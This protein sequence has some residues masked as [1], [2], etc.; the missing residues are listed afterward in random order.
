MNKS[1]KYIVGAVLLYILSTGISY[2]TFSLVKPAKTEVVMSPLPETAKKSSPSKFVIDP[3]LPKTEVCPLNG[4]RYPKKYRDIWETR[5]PLAVMIENSQDARPQSGISLADVIYESVA[6]GGTTRFMAM[7]YCG[8]TLGNINLAPVRSARIYY[9]PWVLEYDALYNHVG[10]A[11]N[12]N[13]PT[14]D[15]R[16]KALCAIGKWGIK[17]MDQFGISFPD[18]YRNYDRLDHPVATEHTMVC[19]TDNLYKIAAKRGFTNVDEDGVSWDKNFTPWKFKDDAKPNDRGMVA[20]I[21]YQFWDGYKQY[22]AHWDYDKENNIYKRSTGGEVHKDLET[23]E[24]LS[25]KDV[26]V[27]LV[28]QTVGVDEHGHLL[29][30]NIG[31][32]KAAIFLDGKAIVGTWAKP[33]KDART[34]FYDAS[35]TEIEFNAGKIWIS[36]T[37][38]DT[39]V[40]YPK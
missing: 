6:E 17:D 27:M 14:V 20:T 25:A 5:R 10:G 19:L 21:D 37:P 16:A 7:F 3:S 1:M 29:F 26:V 40:I 9:L 8:A 33:T 4:V 28:K 12:C 22:A 36:M 18:C 11:G 23:G 34:K 32:G 30:E 38:V 13:D 24:Q 39:N 31:K 2:A 15:D 35:G